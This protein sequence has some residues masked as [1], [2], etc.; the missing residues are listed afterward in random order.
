MASSRLNLSVGRA[1]VAIL[2]VIVSCIAMY[3]GEHRSPSSPQ[4]VITYHNDNNRSGWFSGDAVDACQRDTLDLR[5]IAGHSL[6]WA[7]RCRAA[8]RLRADDRGP[9][10]ARRGLRC[11][12]TNSVY[13]FDAVSGAILWHTS[14]D[15]R[16]GQLQEL[17]R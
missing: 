4:D 13:A 2:I 8:L 14:W 12:E 17:R 16:A 5:N 9:G 10:R 1:A 7:H 15:S 6:G 11:T 3:A